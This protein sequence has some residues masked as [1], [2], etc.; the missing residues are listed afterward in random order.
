MQTKFSCITSECHAIWRTFVLFI[1]NRVAKRPSPVRVGPEIC[2]ENWSKSRKSRHGKPFMDNI[3][4]AMIQISMQYTR[5]VWSDLRGSPQES[6]KIKSAAVAE[7]A[8][9]TM[10]KKNKRVT[11]DLKKDG[12]KVKANIK[13]MISC[14][15]KDCQQTHIFSILFKKGHPLV[16]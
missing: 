7:I 6:P 9:G 10:Y 1:S 5:I 8:S 12:R 15:I 4:M 2:P 16:Q 3:T 14:L 13:I 11:K